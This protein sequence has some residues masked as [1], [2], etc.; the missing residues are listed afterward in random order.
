MSSDISVGKAASVAVDPTNFADET[1]PAHKDGKPADSSV[2]QVE[3]TIDPE[4]EI[5]GA[6]LLLI[7]I[8]VTLAAFLAGLVSEP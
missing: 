3:Q 4:N 8:G 7:H 2:T 5:V 6:R 1:Q